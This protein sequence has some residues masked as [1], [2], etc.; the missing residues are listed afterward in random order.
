MTKTLP[1]FLA[2]ALFVYAQSVRADST[3]AW[4]VSTGFDYSTGDYGDSE[5]TEI[6][7][8]PVNLSYTTGPWMA[9]VTVPWVQIKGPGDVVGAGDGGVVIGGGNTEV[10]T[11]SGLGD[12]WTSLTYSVE[13]IPSDLFFLDLVGKVKIPTAD[14]DKGLGTGEFDYTLQADFFKS[15]G[16]LTPM[17]T[18]AYKIKTDPDDYELD[19]VFYVSAGADYKLSDS[20]NVGATLDYQE[21]STD[22][23]EDAT[24]IFTYL[25][26]RFDEDWRLT[27]YGYTGLTDGSPDIGGGLQVGYYF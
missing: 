15:L 10:D 25:G 16:K 21:A 13:S 14:E 1:L 20:L 12:I 11:Q 24:E 5:D 9:K 8:L 17:L 4:K 23:S 22:S 6:L 3:N 26:Y 18:L 27:V 19:N 2:A 7:Y